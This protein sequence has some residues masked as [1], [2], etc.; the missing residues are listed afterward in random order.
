MMPSR[1]RAASA[2][3]LQEAVR[4]AAGLCPEQPGQRA[5]VES[6]LADA[7][8][9]STRR[10]PVFMRCAFSGGDAG[11]LA[12]LRLLMGRRRR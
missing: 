6:A 9:R 3:A 10:L 8:V 5:F 4:L 1:L 11:D 7:V 12:E 2:V